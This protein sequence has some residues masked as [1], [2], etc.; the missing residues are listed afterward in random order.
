MLSSPWL[1]FNSCSGWL[2]TAAHPVKGP[3]GCGRAV[4]ARACAGLVWQADCNPRQ[5]EGPHRPSSNPH[6]ASSFQ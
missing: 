6:A 5:Q 3:L 2:P 4:D 1:G